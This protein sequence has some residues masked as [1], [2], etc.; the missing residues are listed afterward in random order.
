M[1][2]K[3]RSW[4]GVGSAKPIACT[5]RT[6]SGERSKLLNDTGGWYAGAQKCHCFR[7]NEMGDVLGYAKVDRAVSCSMLKL[8]GEAAIF[9]ASP[10]ERPL[11]HENSRHRRHA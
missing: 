10:A 3:A 2:G 4:M 5:P 7:K 1:M 8:G 11:H 9:L 6:S